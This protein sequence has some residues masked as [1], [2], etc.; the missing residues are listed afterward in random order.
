M[1]KPP[2]R[3]ER[4]YAEIR[5]EQAVLDSILAIAKK[6]LGLD[7]TPDDIHEAVLAG[8]EESVELREVLD[9]LGDNKILR[10]SKRGMYFSTAKE[11]LK[12]LYA[13]SAD[14]PPRPRKRASVDVDAY[15][16]DLFHRYRSG[17]HEPKSDQ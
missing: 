9:E 13:K 6:R 11:A 17:G 16:N 1:R 12:R 3:G 5:V 15:R 14:K 4:E 10:I 7:P 2:G 8:L